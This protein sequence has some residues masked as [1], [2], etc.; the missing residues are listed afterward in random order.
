MSVCCSFSSSDFVMENCTFTRWGGAIGS[1][2]CTVEVTVEFLEEDTDDKGFQKSCS[3]DQYI[4]IWVRLIVFC[5]YRYSPRRNFP[6]H[7][8][9]GFL[10]RVYSKRGHPAATR[11]E[12]PNK[13]LIMTDL[14]LHCTFYF[15]YFC[16]FNFFL[17]FLALKHW[18]E[19]QM[20]LFKLKAENNE[21]LRRNPPLTRPILHTSVRAGHWEVTRSN[22]KCI[23]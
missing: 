23:L 12:Y 22:V 13:L 8:K 1:F 5:F 18:K 11:S 10:R 16:S 3:D 19:I 14:L 9:S 7:L 15:Y 2:L 20:Y 21:P 17:P 6:M 4:T